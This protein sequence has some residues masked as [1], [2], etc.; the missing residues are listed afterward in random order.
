V[1]GWNEGLC[2]DDW[3]FFLRLA[4]HDAVGFVDV[5]VGAYRIHG[6]NVSRTRHRATRIL[7]LTESRQVAL[8]RISL[9]GE[10]YRTLLWAQSHYI[11]AKISF[12]QRR[13]G[14][15][16][17]HLLAYASLLLVSKARPSVAHPIAREV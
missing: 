17:F 11:A 12:L 8:R 16:A 2:I 4:A 5:S 14:A 15:L 7:N 1:A 10:P 9:F 3:D 13:V 6:S